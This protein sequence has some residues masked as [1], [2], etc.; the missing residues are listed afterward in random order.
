[1]SSKIHPDGPNGEHKP[2]SFVLAFTEDESSPERQ[3]FFSSYAEEKISESRD[4]RKSCRWEVVARFEP[5]ERCRQY[6][7]DVQFQNERGWWRES[8]G[9][10]RPPPPRR[11]R[12][13]RVRSLIS[14]LK[15]QFATVIS[16]DFLSIIYRSGEL[17]CP[18]TGC[19]RLRLLLV[20]AAGWFSRP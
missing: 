19:H 13:E 14:L 5:C 3:H 15:S 1:M 7:F 12:N 18:S 4:E 20:F 6:E 16:S 8:Q 11:P 17:A 9:A 10:A 2:L